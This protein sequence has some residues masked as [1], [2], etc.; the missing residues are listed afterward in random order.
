MIGL[1]TS[2]P[3]LAT[4]IQAVVKNLFGMAPRNLFGGCI[5][6]IT[7]IRK[8]SSIFSFSIVD[9]L[10]VQKYLLCLASF[11]SMWYMVGADERISQNEALFLCTV[12]ILFVLQQVSK[13]TFIL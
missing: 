12:C 1:G 11:T 13:S 7:L 3:E 5:T 8:V 9:V 4:T 10:A 6:N 2:L